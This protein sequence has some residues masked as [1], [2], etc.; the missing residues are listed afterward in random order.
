MQG[1]G[2]LDPYNCHLILIT[3]GDQDG[4]WDLLFANNFGS[5][6]R[7]GP[8]H[9][10]KPTTVLVIWNDSSSMPM[11]FKLYF[12]EILEFHEGLFADLQ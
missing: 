4:M 5:P 9:L 11:F 12:G 6:L 2:D 3:T 7:Y 10:K 1:L 8:S